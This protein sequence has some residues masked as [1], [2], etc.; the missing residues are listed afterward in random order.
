VTVLVTL[1]TCQVR[2]VGG[3]VQPRTDGEQ[4]DLKRWRW[5]IR[6]TGSLGFH[7][8]AQGFR[9]GSGSTLHKGWLKGML[10]M[11]DGMAS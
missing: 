11:K 1:G 7:C 2:E 6:L 9:P 5:I 3:T 10:E 8:S 4:R